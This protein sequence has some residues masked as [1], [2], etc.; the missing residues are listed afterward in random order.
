MVEYINSRAKCCS[1]CISTPVRTSCSKYTHC[2][3]LLCLYAVFKWGT[4]VLHLIVFIIGAA[5]VGVGK[6][7]DMELSDI[8]LLFL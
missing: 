6:G 7:K 8:V 1:D 2:E 5:A 4:L 3:I